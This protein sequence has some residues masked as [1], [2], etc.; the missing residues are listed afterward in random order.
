MQV[1]FL[2]QEIH[3]FLKKTDVDTN[4][5]QEIVAFEKRVKAVYSYGKDLFLTKKE[6]GDG[7]TFYFHV[8]RYYMPQI[9]RETY[10]SFGC[11]VVFGVCRLSR[12]GMPK[13]KP[14]I[15]A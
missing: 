6:T 13:E 14:F 11:G 5:E 7:E 4:Y 15:E 10:D 1:L 2:W 8:L 12:E 3:T 9:A